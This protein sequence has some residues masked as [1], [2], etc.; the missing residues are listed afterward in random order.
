M[1]IAYCVLLGS[2]FHCK[3]HHIVYRYLPEEHHAEFQQKETVPLT[4]HYYPLMSYSR[5]F[6]WTS[7][8]SV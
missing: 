6:A 3:A 2:V 8:L 4:H 7:Q 1:K 5:D